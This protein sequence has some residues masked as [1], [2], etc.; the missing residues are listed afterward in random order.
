LSSRITRLMLLNR[1][2]YWLKGL[3]PED[4]WG[5]MYPQRRS[6]TFG[7]LYPD[8]WHRI[9][10]TTDGQLITPAGL[11][12]FATVAPLNSNMRTSSGSHRPDTDGAALLP[13]GQ[14]FWKIVS[15]APRAAL[16]YERQVWLRRGGIILGVITLLLAFV[17][18]RLAFAR[19]LRMHTE[20]S[21]YMRERY[22]HA[23][24]RGAATLVSSYGEISFQPFIDCIGPVSEAS[25][26]YLFLSEE[27]ND[28]G[29][30]E[31]RLAAQW[32]PEASGQHPDGP[33]REEH[34]LS[35]CFRLWAE[36]LARG[37]TIAGSAA[38]FPAEER[39]L[40]E[41]Q[42]I[43]T[44]LV[45][46]L[47][48][49]HRLYGLMGFDNCLADSSWQEAEA[50][51]LHNAAS[52][53]TQVIKQ[54]RNETALLRAKDEWE[55]TFDSVPDSIAI[56]DQKYRIVR[57]NKALARQ[58]GLPPWECIGKTCHILIHAADVPIT[59]C[60][61]H[62][63]L[64][65]GN[66]HSVE[67]YDAKR[68]S[69]FHITVSPIHNRNGEL[70][71][72]VHVARDI[73]KRKKAENA[74]RETHQRLLT[75]LDSL[76]ALVYVIDINNFEILFLNR[77]A[78]EIFGDVTGKTCWQTIQ[79]G[80]TG[81]CDFCPNEILRQAGTESE[82]PHIW[83][84][85][86]TINSRWYENRDKAITWLDG[87]LV[88]IQIGTDITDRRQ[89]REA[90]QASEEQLRTLIDSTPDIVCFKDGEG[91]WLEAN[92][93]DLELFRLTGVDYH[94]KKDRELAGHTHP[95]YRQAFLAC[96]DSDEK[97]WSAGRAVQSE[98]IIP[99]V[100]DGQRI[101]DIIKVPLF[102]GDG[103]R[104]GLVVLG[105][106]ITE[107][108]K[109]E[110]KLRE[111]AVTQ[112]VLLREVNHRV[113]NNLAAIIS[114]LHKE[115]D[116]AKSDGMTDSLSLPHDLEGRIRGLSTVHSLL[117]EHAWRPLPLA[118]LCERVAQ[119]A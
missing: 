109:A 49:E 64:R 85:F 32:R 80:M 21:L 83:E 106:D 7:A 24:N 4:E 69:H 6:K 52:H 36:R 57:V 35:D 93:A 61:H 74:L 101:Y 97:A 84:A 105:R 20:S 46:P 91:R 77:Y 12:T 92:R 3:H 108:K 41:A 87:R 66:P 118:E 39:A 113:K 90:L 114:M 13:P 9:N 54:R 14:Y 2:G 23:L 65:D 110:E 44:I 63:L 75:V 22:L 71:G 111:Y 34:P 51:F 50:D 11:F 94:H 53:L 82:K 30:E 19:H 10:S 47:I 38:D 42:G 67:L 25:R 8:I 43:R 56:I 27:N 81:P 62:Q 73:T 100:E 70:L 86:N 37:E 117:T 60:P 28:Q 18:W 88:K 40:L 103:R 16:D 102:H 98:E 107:R 115:E 26:A 76:A 68:G 95:L 33:T 29:G 119:A 1:D 116:R 5:F 55:R 112:E 48:V 58:V 99:T 96:E 59:E 104:K 15:L 17:S 78:K 79:T 45:L 89:T 72:S 31:L